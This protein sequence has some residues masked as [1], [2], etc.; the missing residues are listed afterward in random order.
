MTDCMM[1]EA[2]MEASS[3]VSENRPKI[4][5]NKAG[6]IFFND[7]SFRNCKIRS[8]ISK[9]ALLVKVSARM[10]RMGICSKLTDGSINS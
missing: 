8:F 9:E 10:E 3:G 2:L 5:S 1:I 4:S 6:G 7:K